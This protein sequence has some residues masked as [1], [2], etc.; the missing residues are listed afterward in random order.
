MGG[1]ILLE[2]NVGE[3]IF[4]P[5]SMVQ[6][7]VR[8]SGEGGIPC[9]LEGMLR[10]TPYQYNCRGYYYQL[11]KE[12]Q[13]TKKGH[14]PKEAQPSIS[15]ACLDNIPQVNAPLVIRQKPSTSNSSLI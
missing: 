10:W 6:A 8:P 13:S 1:G 15:K 9:P 11:H 3:H 2:Y 5:I 4:G 7:K 12:V 14:G